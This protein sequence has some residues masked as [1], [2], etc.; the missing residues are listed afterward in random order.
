MFIAWALAYY[1]GFGLATYAYAVLKSWELLG[2]WDFTLTTKR[3]SGFPNP[4]WILFWA[5]WIV[6][7]VKK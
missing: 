6:E 3:V 1:L 5:G 2:Y 4:K 7:K